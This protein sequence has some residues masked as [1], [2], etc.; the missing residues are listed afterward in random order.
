MALKQKP[1]W[2]VSS[3][4]IMNRVDSGPFESGR[5]RRDAECSLAAWI[6][7]FLHGSPPGFHSFCDR[8]DCR[9]ERNSI[10][11]RKQDFPGESAPHGYRTLPMKAMLVMPLRF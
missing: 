5:R 4:G 8:A 1:A 6:D 3:S 10:A 9:Y 2:D 11:G 7:F